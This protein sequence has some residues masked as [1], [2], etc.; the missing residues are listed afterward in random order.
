[1]FEVPGSDIKSVH[2]TEDSVNGGCPEYEKHGENTANNPVNDPSP[3]NSTTTN[4][5][6]ETE[7]AQVRVKQ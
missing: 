3:Q 4:S 2:I 7:S 6:E 5:E 1:M